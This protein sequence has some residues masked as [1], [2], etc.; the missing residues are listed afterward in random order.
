MSSGTLSVAVQ[1]PAYRARVNYTDQN[2]RQYQSRREGKHQAELRLVE[3]AFRV[4]P[5]GR[6]LDAP[7][8]GGRVAL[9]LAGKGHQLPGADLSEP[10]LAIARENIRQSGLPIAA[11]RQDVESLGYADRDFDT[12]I[13]FRFFHHL[14]TP[15]I[16][17]RVVRELC[18]VADRFVA[19]SFF[20]PYSITSAKRRMRATLGLG[21]LRHHQTPLREVRGYFESAGFHLVRD[22][23]Q[24]P[25]WHTLHLAVFE[26]NAAA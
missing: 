7:C 24:F 22:F 21:K 4:I 16:R 23:A 12:A 20:S 13:C 15:E 5:T 2:A 6:V 8:G 1:S 18:R 11:D 14:P 17:A 19:L 26:R 9:L 3:R 25:F 10:M